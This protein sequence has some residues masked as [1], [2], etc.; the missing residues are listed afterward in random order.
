MVLK[1]TLFSIITA[2]SMLTCVSANAAFSLVATHPEAFNRYTAVSAGREIKVLRAFNGLLYMGYGQDGQGVIP[3]SC[4]PFYINPDNGSQWCE[5]ITRYYDPLTNVLG[6]QNINF[7]SQEVDTIEV[8]NGNMFIPANDPEGHYLIKCT[9]S[10]CG[11]RTVW[12]ITNPAHIYSATNLGGDLYLAG[13]GWDKSAIIWRSTN[14]GDNWS[15]FR[16]EYGGISRYYYV[17]GPFDNHIYVQGNQTAH[18]PW[19]YNSNA[20]SGSHDLG[21]YHIYRMR[22][23]AGKLVYTKLNQL[24]VYDGSP[25]PISPVTFPVSDFTIYDGWLYL[26]R[27]DT[28]TIHRTNNL[29]HFPSV[30]IAPSTAISI[31]VLN[32]HIY[33]GTINSE[34]HKSDKNVGDLVNAGALVPPNS[35][36]L[37]D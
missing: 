36:L 18:V 31:E 7:R 23:F 19:K 29:Q 3:G 1:G 30:D 22:T 21:K 37:L 6:N 13:S 24:M 9:T 33:V 16:K 17:G 5:L 25:Q 15:E 11:Y 14:N 28:H 10:N 12:D 2:L 8:L 32:D 34:I 20:W 35:L 27:E 26:L 4:T